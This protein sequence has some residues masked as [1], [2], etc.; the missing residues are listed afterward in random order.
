M[1]WMMDWWR[2]QLVWGGIYSSFWGGENS[3]RIVWFVG[4]M[5][6]SLVVKKVRLKLL[7]FC[8][9]W[10]LGVSNVV[11]ILR[12]QSLIQIY[13]EGISVRW[14]HGGRKWQAFEYREMKEFWSLA[15]C[16]CF[17]WVKERE[18]GV[19]YWFSE[20][21]KCTCWLDL[22]VSTKGWLGGKVTH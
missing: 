14:N 17:S 7:F 13:C 3:T 19:A 15:C 10:S 5:L 1:N 16:C 20:L 21:V 18:W 6:C 9:M 2:I 12:I 4:C 22:H 11:M 8:G